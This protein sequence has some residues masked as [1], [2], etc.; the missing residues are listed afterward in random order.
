M[1]LNNPQEVPLLPLRRLPA[2]RPPLIHGLNR[3]TQGGDDN[4]DWK[5]AYL[6]GKGHAGNVPR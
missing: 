6:F 4:G 1:L 5:R 2:A 3:A